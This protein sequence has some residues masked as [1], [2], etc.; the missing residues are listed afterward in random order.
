MSEPGVQRDRAG[1]AE[2]SGLAQKHLVLL[3]PRLAT[4]TVDGLIAYL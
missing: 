3:E 1:W 2:G 4:G